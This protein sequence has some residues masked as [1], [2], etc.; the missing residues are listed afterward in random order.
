MPLDDE[1]IIGLLLARDER[2]LEALNEKYRA[3]CTSLARDVTGSAMDAEECVNDTWLRVWNTIPPER[4]QSL[5]HYVLRITRNLSLDKWRE[6]RADK[7][8]GGECAAVL[9]ELTECLPSRSGVE[10]EYDAAELRD[11]IDR[12][13]RA[14]PEKRRYIFIRRYY[15]AEPIA[16]IAARSGMTKGS[17][18]T[19]LCRI[20]KKLRAFLEKEGYSI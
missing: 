15:Y 20:R 7:R 4:P 3:A 8:G 9:D 6:G 16:A 19:A 11:A 2:G 1:A 5:K 17:V 18:M 13:V 14:L 12:F 10:E